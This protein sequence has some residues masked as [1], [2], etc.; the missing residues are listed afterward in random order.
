MIEYVLDD[1]GRDQAV[2]YRLITTLPDP[3]TAPA[4]EPAALYSER[5]E[6]ETTLEEI[7]TVQLGTRTV[8]PS[9]TPDLVY[10]DIYAQLADSRRAG[11]LVNRDFHPTGPDRLR[12]TDFTYVPTWAGTVYLAFCLDAFSC[13]ILGW[14]AS[15][16]K[17]TSL[18][19]DVVDQALWQRGYHLN[20]QVTGL[21]H[22]SDAGSTHPSRSP[23]VWAR[24]GQ[25]PRSVPS[26]TL[27]TTPWPRPRSACSRP[28]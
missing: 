23:S 19:L 2:H 24:P 12:V 1:P 18:V 15:P 20:Q 25:P 14:K 16:S 4:A 6:V 21:I 7:K 10:Q 22:H 11:D 9:R 26:P 3:A 27:T 17:R 5:W 13:Q 28:S 8:L